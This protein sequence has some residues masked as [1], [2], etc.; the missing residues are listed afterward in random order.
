MEIIEH[1]GSIYQVNNF[2]TAEEIKSIY[3]IIDS[4][5]TD[6]Q[7]WTSE[8]HADNPESFWVGK[9]HTPKE[10]PEFMDNILYRI[11]TEL[12]NVCDTTYINYIDSIQRTLPDYEPMGN[13]RDNEGWSEIKMGIVIYINDD[14]QGGEISYPDLG[15]SI[16]PTAGMLAIHPSDIIH[17]VLPVSGSPRYIITTFVNCKH[18]VGICPISFKR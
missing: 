17:R 14:Y 18:D 12:I 5:P 15:L 3:E 10:H 13:H 1:P 11:Q 9:I 2:L 7:S 4:A 8:Q 6:M 16:K